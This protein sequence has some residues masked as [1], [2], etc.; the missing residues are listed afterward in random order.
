MS[1]NVYHPNHYNG[2]Y[3]CIEV[4][5]DVFGDEA[6]KTF[7]KLNA[8]KYLWRASKKNGDEDLEKAY[9]YT[10]YMKTNLITKEEDK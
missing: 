8:F 5:R 6:V 3:E 10:N 7:C 1:S 2:K 4:M 9:Y